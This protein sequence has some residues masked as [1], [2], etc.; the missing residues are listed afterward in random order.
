[1]QKWLDENRRQY[2]TFLRV[3][4]WLMQE[5]FDPV[6]TE[7]LRNQAYRIDHTRA[8]VDLL[9]SFS[10]PQ[11]ST[12]LKLFATGPLFHPRRSIWTEAVDVEII[13]R[14]PGIDVGQLLIVLGKVAGELAPTLAPGDLTMVF[15]NVD[16]LRRALLAMGCTRGDVEDILQSL[17]HGNL[18]A[19]EA[20][21]SKAPNGNPHL[22]RPQTVDSFF[23]MLNGYLPMTAPGVGFEPWDTLWDLS[24]VGNWSYYSGLVFT[25]YH[26]R[27]G[28]VLANGGRFDIATQSQEFAGAGFTLYLDAWQ[29]ALDEAQNADVS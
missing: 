8:M 2:E 19:A 14:G 4:N 7:P 12:P 26:T 5:E 3:V 13:G 9:G 29:S 27:T 25:L 10:G 16:W 17:Q 15:G 20:K 1:M 23:S 11:M 24:L 18:E 28:Q 6:P 22:I 21:I